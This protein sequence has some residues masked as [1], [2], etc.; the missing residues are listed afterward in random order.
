MTELELSLNNKNSF[1][2]LAVYH[3]SILPLAKRHLLSNAWQTLKIYTYV[4]LLLDQN[5]N[6]VNV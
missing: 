5:N 3:K 4:S 2:V 1:V 6:I